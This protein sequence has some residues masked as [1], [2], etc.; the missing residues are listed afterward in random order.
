ML[1]GNLADVCTTWIRLYAYCFWSSR[2]SFTKNS[3]KNF[4]LLQGV[5]HTL[6]L[7]G[8]W[9]KQLAR[10]QSEQWGSDSIST[11]ENID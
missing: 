11:Q 7:S 3:P 9:A 4:Q 10:Q 6:S 2:Y 5:D 1:G 8:Q